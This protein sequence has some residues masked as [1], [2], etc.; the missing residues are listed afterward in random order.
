M[1]CWDI[2]Q[3][4]HGFIECSRHAAP[5]DNAPIRPLQI[6]ELHQY[7]VCLPP[8]LEYNP[9]LQTS[10]CP[11]S[12][13][14]LE[15]IKNHFQI[16]ARLRE[17]HIPRFKFQTTPNQPRHSGRQNAGRYFIMHNT[18]QMLPLFNDATPNAPFRPPARCPY[19]CLLLDASLGHKSNY[20]PSFNVSLF[21]DAIPNAPFR[22]PARCP[23]HFKTFDIH[24]HL[25]FSQEARRANEAENMFT[26]L[27]Y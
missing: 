19:M 22:P 21:N 20:T 2:H 26:N 3:T 24:S 8:Q 13:L 7:F 15:D 18:Q 9:T 14:P 25:L 1:H 23:S 5:A 11:R 12:N 17:R 6:H 27:K 10:V 16:G 4:L